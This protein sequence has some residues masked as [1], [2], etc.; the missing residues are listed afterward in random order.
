MF[1]QMKRVVRL[2]KR[3]QYFHPIYYGSFSRDTFIEIDASLSLS[4][5]FAFVHEN[6][7][8][9]VHSSSG[10]FSF[11]FHENKKYPDA[12]R[13]PLKAHIKSGSDECF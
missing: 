3:T 13:S 1:V 12:R 4:L 8:H 6:R 9:D 2:V 10:L 5:S 7:P 11:Y